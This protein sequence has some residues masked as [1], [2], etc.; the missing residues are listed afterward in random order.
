MKKI[1]LTT[2]IAVLLFICSNEIQSQTTQSQLNQVELFKQFLGTYQANVGKDTVEVWETQQYGNA[3]V[4]NVSYIIKG[5]KKPNYINNAGFDPNEDKFK[6]YL[7]FPNGG[8]GTWIGYFTAEKTFT[9]K[10]VQNFD[11]LVVQLKLQG[12]FGTNEFVWTVF[13]PS[14]LKTGEY[15]YKKVK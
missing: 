4:M 13:N 11:P 6:G 10:L 7:L 9:G 12:V 1:Y 15:K 14:G 5:Q 2:V 3:L 8:Y